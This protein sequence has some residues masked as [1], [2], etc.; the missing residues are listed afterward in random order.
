M[1]HQIQKHILRTLSLKKKARYTEIKPKTVE[2]NIF[3]YHLKTLMRDGYVVLKDLKYSLSP[4]GKQFVDRV[5]FETFQ[6]RIQPK[7]VTILVIENK[8]KYLLYKRRRLPFI[9]SIGFPYGKIHFGEHIKDAAHKELQEKTGLTIDKLTHRGE[10]YMAIHDEADLISHALFHVF[11]G[12]DPKGTLR[13]DTQIGK[14][15]WGKLEDFNKKDLIPGVDKIMALVKKNKPTQLFFAEY[16]LN[17][18]EEN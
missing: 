12:K 7:I 9:D 13:E 18:S 4:K 1:M 10:V 3:T 15:F 5:S 6:E 17:V 2:G 11:T 14:C 8:G 16:F